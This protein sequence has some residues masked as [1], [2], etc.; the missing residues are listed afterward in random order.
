MMGN[1]MTGL[2][3]CSTLFQNIK[4]VGPIIRGFKDDRER[5]RLSD[6]L[7]R[8]VEMQHGQALFTG[9]TIR[10]FV[11]KKKLI[12]SS[13]PQS[14]EPASQAA[15]TQAWKNL[16]SPLCQLQSVLREVIEILDK[17]QTLHF[18]DL[19][20]YRSMFFDMEKRKPLYDDL[21]QLDAA[22]VDDEVLGAS[23][24][25]YDELRKRIPV[26]Q[27]RLAALLAGGQSSETS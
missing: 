19:P 27:E 10:A 15:C 22:K 1:I 2:R 5:T 23:A 7:K 11:R 8:L 21:L 17:T 3:I 25:E 26:F 20:T 18:K 24:D 6:L 13:D 14:R 4:E 12:K 9:D 16:A